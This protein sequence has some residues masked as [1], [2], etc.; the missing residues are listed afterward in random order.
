ML[1]KEFLDL[2]LNT[3]VFFRL[4]SGMTFVLRNTEHFLKQRTVSVRK[5]FLDK[6]CVVAWHRVLRSFR[7]S[8][9]QIRSQG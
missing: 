6:F 5:A 2:T 1:K 7:M 9:L 3:S 8:N 4:A